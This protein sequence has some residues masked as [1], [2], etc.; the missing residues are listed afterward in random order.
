MMCSR[1]FDMFNVK[2]NRVKFDANERTYTLQ[3]LPKDEPDRKKRYPYRYI[4]SHCHGL[5]IT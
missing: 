2:L 4:H 1:R 3:G 5:R